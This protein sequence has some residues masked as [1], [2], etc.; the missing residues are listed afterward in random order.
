MFWAAGLKHGLQRAGIHVI[1]EFEEIPPIMTEKHKV[2]QI[3]V[4][5][6]RNTMQAGEGSS[7]PEKRLTIRVSQVA[8]RVRIAVADNGS[9]ILPEH[10][11]RIFAH[12]FTTKKDGHGFG[13]HGAALAAKEMGGSLAVQSE[14]PGRGATFTLELPMKG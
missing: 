14:G 9:G 6:V 10:L 2:L 13:L 12:G 4:N 3:L 11:S 8:G 7:T 5:L 1:K